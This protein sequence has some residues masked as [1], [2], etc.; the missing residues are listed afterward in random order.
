MRVNLPADWYLISDRFGVALAP[1]WSA[2]KDGDTP[3]MHNRWTRLFPTMLI[4]GF[5]GA[6]IAQTLEQKK[7]W[8]IGPNLDVKIDACTVLIQS[9]RV[10]TQ[11]S[12]AIVYA[13]R[14][15]AFAS[16]GQPD[17]GIQDFD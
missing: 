9:G 13:N 5:S 17:R 2:D 4:A 11:D 7:A 3:A 16:R 6:V 10:T 14:G 8:C 12:L 15:L 1:L